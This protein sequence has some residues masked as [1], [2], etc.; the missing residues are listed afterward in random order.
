MLRCWACGHPFTAQRVRRDS[1]LCPRTEANGG[2]YELYRCP[3]CRRESRIE[4]TPHGRMYA[5][6]EHEIG[7][8][9]YLFSWVE[10]LTPPDFLRLV[11]WHQTYSDR[12]RHFFLRDGDARYARG[13]W[14]ERLILWWGRRGRPFSATP[15]SADSR[16]LDAGSGVAS[17]SAATRGGP[18]GPAHSR[19]GRDPEAGRAQQS[20]PLPS[21]DVAR[22]HVPHPYRILG[23]PVGASPAEIRAAFRRL[24]RQWHPDKRGGEDAVQ[25][26][27]ATRRLAELVT[28]YESLQKERKG[29]A[30]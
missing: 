10:G 1:L 12:R 8:V 15:G 13:G 9:E 2:P 14:L 29:P 28:A 6:P 7:L 21:P 23:V 25:L 18:E 30:S 17:G 20:G 26:A 5:S 3:A 4:T 11:A 24:A 16:P 19:E 22:E 27:E